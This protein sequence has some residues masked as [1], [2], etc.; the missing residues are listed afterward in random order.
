MDTQGKKSV[1][2]TTIKVAAHCHVNLIVNNYKT[3]LC[4]GPHWQSNPSNAARCSEGTPTIPIKPKSSNATACLFK[5]QGGTSSNSLAK[6]QPQQPRWPTN[7]G[8]QVL[9]SCPWW[10]ANKGG[11]L[12]GRHFWPKESPFT[13]RTCQETRLRRGGEREST[14]RP[15]Q[16]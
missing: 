7:R 8:D 11:S 5:Q 15:S 3:V 9:Q 13:I 16:S 14:R 6:Q 12:I 10:S 4:A 1:L 2:L